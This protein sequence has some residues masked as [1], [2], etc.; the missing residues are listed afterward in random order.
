MVRI[1]LTKRHI[2]GIGFIE[3]GF[4]IY[5]AVI[6]VHFERSKTSVTIS[7]VVKFA[8]CKEGWE[9]YLGVNQQTADEFLLLSGDTVW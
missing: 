7:N 5:E 2:G 6:P 9:F 4:S 3:K 1:D 8:I